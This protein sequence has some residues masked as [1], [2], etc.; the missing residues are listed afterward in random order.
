MLQDQCGWKSDLP[1]ILSVCL[2][3]LE[4]DSVLRVMQDQF[5]PGMLQC[6]VLSGAS[7]DYHILD[8]RFRQLSANQCN[9]ST[10]K[11]VS[12][13]HILVFPTSATA[14]VSGAISLSVLKNNFFLFQSAVQ[15]AF[16]DHQTGDNGENDFGFGIDMNDLDVNPN[17]N[18][19]ELELGDLNDIFD[20]DPFGS[21]GGGTSPSGSPRG[22]NNDQPGSPSKA[23]PGSDPA[24]RSVSSLTP[25]DLCCESQLNISFNTNCYPET[26][27]SNKTLT[28]SNGR[29]ICYRL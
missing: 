19:N 22:A 18:D 15:A 1:T 16:N 4:P 2:I 5:T 26:E 17:D 13:T 3:S 24:F 14:Q 11:D 21:G 9:L 7:I 12:V 27:T 6:S 28:I 20:S 29:T 8:E 23:A 10:P 25:V